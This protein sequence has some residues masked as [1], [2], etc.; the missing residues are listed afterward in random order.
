MADTHPDARLLSLYSEFEPLGQTIDELDRQE[1]VGVGLGAPE[2]M[3]DRLH[4]LGEA[5][6]ATPAQ[7]MDG[8][9]IKAKVARWC[10][11]G[12]FER[13]SDG[14]NDVATLYSL[15]ADLLAIGEGS[16]CERVNGLIA[17]RC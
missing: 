11:G 7:S 12:E 17:A 16:G 9:V 4:D 13:P 3:R 8:L 1:C 10:C 6:L 15:A 14:L 2:V 5:I